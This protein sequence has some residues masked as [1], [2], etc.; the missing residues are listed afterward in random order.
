LTGK[1][2]FGGNI[3]YFEIKFCSFISNTEFGEIHFTLQFCGDTING[4]GSAKMW[5]KLA[6]LS[7]KFGHGSHFTREITLNDEY[8]SQFLPGHKVCW[9]TLE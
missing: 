9:V 5:T 8:L 3:F 7:R 1:G 4:R 2:C 6:K